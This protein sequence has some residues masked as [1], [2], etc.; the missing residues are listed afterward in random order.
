[1][2][3]NSLDCKN[4]YFSTTKQRLLKAL[5]VVGKTRQSI[6]VC[7]IDEEKRDFKENANYSLLSCEERIQLELESLGLVINSKIDFLLFRHQSNSLI[8]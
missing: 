1:M 6:N 4:A 2:K 5:I 3:R 8:L 7:L